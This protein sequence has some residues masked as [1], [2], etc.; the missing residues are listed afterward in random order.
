MSVSWN[1]AFIPGVGVDEDG[2]RM[3]GVIAEQLSLAYS[4][5]RDLG[6]DAFHPVSVV[7]QFP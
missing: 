7:D 6:D 4:G 2:A 1:A 5:G 3:T